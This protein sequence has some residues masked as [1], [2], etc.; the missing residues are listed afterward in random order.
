MR[1][2]IIGAGP[3]LFENKHL[4]ILKR[5]DYEGVLIVP[6]VM[7]VRALEAGITPDKFKNY[8]IATLEDSWVTKDLMD[9]PIVKQWGKE[10]TAIVSARAPDVTR[11]YCKDTF[12]DVLLIERPEVWQ[13]SNNGLF[14][15]TVAYNDLEVDEVCLIGMDHAT[16]EH[17]FCAISR[18]SEIYKNAFKEITNPETGKTVIMNP[19]QQFWRI[20]F[21]HYVN[22]IYNKVKLVN[23]TQG[24]ALFGEN[25]KSMRFVEWLALS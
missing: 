24:G 10:I 21:L 25:I 14:M 5:S 9:Y 23:C 11:D 20:Q 22:K 6:E 16:N 12:K 15:Y 7:A 1:C 8:Y 4:E 17:E 3:S 2:I 13:I 18:D 19:I